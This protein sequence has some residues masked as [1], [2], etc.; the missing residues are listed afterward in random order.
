MN[1]INAIGVAGIG[2]FEEPVQ[3][4]VEPG[5]T[6]I[7]G[8]NKASGDKARNGNGVG[9]SLL[10]SA[11]YE[12]L[13]DEPIVGERSDRIRTGKRVVSFVSHHGK[14]ILVRRVARTSGEKF[15]IFEDGKDMQIRRVADAKQFLAK[16]W[17]LNTTEHNTF[18]HLD[19]R[20]PHP[21]VMGTSA[22]RK[23]FFTEFFGLDRLDAERKLYRAKLRELENV[24]AAYDELLSQYEK[25]KEKRLTKAERVATEKLRDTL[26]AK[27]ESLQKR[28]TAV[29]STVRLMQF[30][31]SA[32]E[33]IAT[34]VRAYGEVTPEIIQQAVEDNQWELN[35]VE[36]KLID[37]RAW[38]AYRRDN[39]RYLEAFN[40]LSVHA[41]E[42][43]R[44]HSREKAQQLA[45]DAM[46]NVMRAKAELATLDDRLDKIEYSLR[47]ATAERVDPPAED[48]QDLRVLERTYRHHLDHAQKFGN[49][50]CE[51]CGQ[52]VQI[53]DPAVV[54]KKLDAV[55][56][57]LELHEAAKKYSAMVERRRE[58]KKEH[59]DLTAAYEKIEADR[60]QALPIAR[61]YREIRD[62][63]SKPQPFT[64]KKLET[65][66][67][68]K[69]KADIVERRELL[70]FV[71]PH[72]ETIAEFIALTPEQK[73][74]ARNIDM[75]AE[76]MN[77]TQE[78]YT[79]VLTKLQV[80]DSLRDQLI[81]MR[82]RL[83]V[84]EK[85]LKNE[86]Y[87]KMLVKAYSDQNIKKL[88]VDAIGERLMTLVN[89][90]AMQI[91]EENYRFEFV[92]DTEVRLLVYRKNG[93]KI[94]PPT[95][96]R[97]LSG[98]ESVF[99]T[100]ILTCALLNFVPAHKRCNLMILDEPASHLSD[101]NVEILQSILKILNTMIPSIIVITP[102]LDEIYKGARNIT[103]VKE[104]GKARI[105]K[106]H[107][108][109]ILKNGSI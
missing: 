98:A 99:F 2:P 57:K 15:E 102:K 30:G 104:K 60:K 51:T 8:L 74:A 62:L 6:V 53:K 90:Y 86:R 55:R 47:K 65:N 109:E 45:K 68:E 78:K 12:T 48:E 49:G 18:V 31:E 108:T 97:K 23:Q 33:A 28:V 25:T 93:D 81:D 72:A 96:V 42:F 82:E 3:F 10:V 26:A 50:K 79:Q 52:P 95:D 103:I 84:M 39:A 13:N 19:S 87:V 4:K 1:V 69:M 5:L 61:L 43:L 67:L 70:R 32:K 36:Q 107:P 71:G 46:T 35:D 54:H 14:K 41:K 64:G 27:L 38:D 58:L 44:E 16:H 83:E 100:L 63:P 29:Q 77:R 24:R 34:L 59:S 94:S 88:A 56:H 66:V 91:F 105:I 89:S 9:K 11:L 37:S 22:Q 21:L 73:E 106:S 101:H 17:P 80:N 20:V 92:W 40:G 76:Q 85:D 75:L 7:Y